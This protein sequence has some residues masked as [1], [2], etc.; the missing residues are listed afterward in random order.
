MKTHTHIIKLTHA[1]AHMH[2]LT[3]I[4]T[5]TYAHTPCRVSRVSVIELGHFVAYFYNEAMVLKLKSLKVKCNSLSQ[6]CFILAGALNFLF[7]NQTY[8]FQFLKLC[9]QFKASFISLTARCMCSVA[10]WMSG[11]KIGTLWL[12][13]L[14]G[15]KQQQFFS[16]GILA[17]GVQQINEHKMTCGVLKLLKF[18]NNKM[19]YRLLAEGYSTG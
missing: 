14:T 1:H 13:C 6:L 8:K 7:D 15:S 17:Q 16:I 9:S 12:A 3:Y 18:M 11:A 5:A 19:I 2:I 10:C 4:H